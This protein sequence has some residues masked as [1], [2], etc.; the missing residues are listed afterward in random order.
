MVASFP[1]LWFHPILFLS[2]REEEI[3]KVETC[4]QVPLDGSHAG[5]HSAS[6]FAR[7]DQSESAVSDA[8]FPLLHPRI[9]VVLMGYPET[10]IK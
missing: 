5:P 4:F 6:T 1:G 10:G 2:G 8:G 9:L 3:A 7:E